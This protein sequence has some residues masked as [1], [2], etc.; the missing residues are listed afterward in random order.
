MEDIQPGEE[1]NLAAVKDRAV[2]GVVFLSGRMFFLQGISFFGFFLLT[3]FLGKEEIGLFFAVSEIVAILGYFSDVGLAAALIQSKEKPTTQEIR[4]TFTIQ[5]A[6]VVSLLILTLALIPWLKNFYHIGQAGVFLLGSLLFGFFMSS[7]KT[8]PSVLLER[9]LRFD[10]LV[11]VESIEALLFYGLAVW[12]AW[13]GFGVASYAWAI[14][15]R[16]LV[17][18]VLIYL[19]SPWQIGFAFEKKSLRRLLRFGIP[20]QANTFLAVI[21]DRLM[22]I[23]LWKL[24]GASGVGI[25]GWAQKWAQMPLRFIMDSVMKVT[26]PAYARMQ[27]HQEELGKAIEKTLFF[28]SLAVFPMLMGIGLLAKPLIFLIPQYGKWEV[29]LIALYFFLINS[30]LG[31]LTTP[32]TNALNAIGRIKVVFKLMIM[33]TVLTWAIYPFLAIKYG[34]NGVAAGAALV[35]L[36]SVWAIIIAKHYLKFNFWRAVLKPTLASLVMG[37]FLFL[38]TWF[39]KINLWTLLVLIVGSIFFYFILI[40][41]MVGQQLL[42]DI[43]KLFYAFKNR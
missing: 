34:F 13:K 10:L 38:S 5:Q 25:L 27:D 18:V 29:A 9:K 41:L 12:L 40:Y 37:F 43:K 11:V 36:S 28:V 4:S 6:L 15:V 24:I 19:F 35:S 33:W 1:M 16:S 39:L 20:F 42:A 21:K 32:L 2:K 22:N 30:A 3:I 26:F 17:G 8:I 14:L 31:A 7:L 23:F